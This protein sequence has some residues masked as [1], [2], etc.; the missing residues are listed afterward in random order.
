MFF[1][2]KGKNSEIMSEFKE[3]NRERGEGSKGN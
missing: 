2:L 1:I 3:R